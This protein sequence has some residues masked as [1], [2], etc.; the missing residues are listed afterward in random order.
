MSYLAALIINCGVQKLLMMNTDFKHY[1]ILK[2]KHTTLHDK[3]ATE[4]TGS[5]LDNQ[6]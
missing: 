3:S 1:L 6:G 2:R 4:A 5:C